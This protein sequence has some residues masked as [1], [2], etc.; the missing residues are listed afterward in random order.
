MPFTG[1]TYAP[2]SQVKSQDLD[3]VVKLAQPKRTRFPTP[4]LA[5]NWASSLTGSPASPWLASSGAGDAYVDLDIPQGYRLGT[6]TLLCAGNASANLTIGIDKS[7]AQ[8]AANVSLG[9]LLLSALSATAAD[10]ILNMLA[11]STTNAGGQTVTVSSF[12]GFGRY[13]RSAGSFITD[14][15]FVGQVVSWAGFVNGGNNVASTTITAL[16]ATQM[17]TSNAGFVAETSAA[18]ATQADGV[19]PAVDATFSAQMK[20]TASATGL[21]VKALRYTCIAA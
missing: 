5:T 1:L 15:F 12:G 6:L 7:L 14:G 13:T 18:N 21:K 2:G 17:D 8:D 10:K 4:V 3:L 9:A 16:S 11:A 20:L 19:S